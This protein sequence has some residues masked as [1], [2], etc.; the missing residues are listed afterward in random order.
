MK[1]IGRPPKNG[2]VEPE[3]FLRALM[4]TFAYSNARAGGQKHSAAVREAVEFVRRLDPEMSISETE[5]KRVLAEFLP[6]DNKVALAVDYSILEGEEA[7]R[8]R[9]F[10]ARMREFAENKSSTELTDQN[11]RKPLRSFRFGFGERPNYQRHN[12]KTSIPRI[13][14]S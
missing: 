8:R 7:A 13:P 3:R 2:V 12:A 10:F 6:H 11:L 9:S 5:V 4:V 1:K 14:V